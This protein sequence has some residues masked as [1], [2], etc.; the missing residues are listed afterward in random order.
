[1]NPP[2]TELAK[3]NSSISRTTRTNCSSSTMTRKIIARTG[4]T[5]RS[6][7]INLADEP[8]HVAKRKEMEQLLL[9]EMRRYDDPYRFSGQPDVNQK[10]AEPTQPNIVFIFADDWGWGDLSC[11]G[12]K[13]L[14]T[15]NIDRL[16]SEGTDFLQFN[17]LNPVCSPSRTATMTGRFPAR[18]SIHQHFAAPASN[19]QRNMPDCLTSVPKVKKPKPKK[20]A[21]PAKPMKVSVESVPFSWD[22]VPVYAH[23]GKSSDDFTPEQLDFLAEHFDFIA[24]EKSQAV[25]KRGNTEAGIAEAAR[26]IKQ[27]KPNAKVLFYWNAFLDIRH[28]QASR[29]FPKEGHLNDRRGEPIMVRTILSTYDL[30]RADVRDWWSDAAAKAVRDGGCDGIFA[31]AL[32]QVTAE[33]KR[34]RLGAAKSQAL[35]QGLVTMLQETQRKIGSDKLIIYNGLRGMDGSEFLPMTNGAMIEHFG[36]FSGVGKEKMAEDLEAMRVAAKAGKIV[37]FKAWPG[38]SWLDTDMMKKPH[39]ELAKLA[40]DPAHLS[41]GVLPRGC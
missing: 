3:R 38:F 26:Q 2:K 28:Y 4:V 7:Q 39:N 9:T 12:H 34:K 22:R 10:Q 30:S 37:C 18:Y 29:E 31:D 11:H 5:P 1:M 17:V 21:P 19:H 8:Q 27:R 36:Y 6:S 25:R 23:V 20:P 33:S 15:P 40:R 41:I 14:K 24:F 13:W 35:N 32:L 16:A